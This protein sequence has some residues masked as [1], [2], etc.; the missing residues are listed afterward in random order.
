MSAYRKRWIE[1]LKARQIP[2]W[3]INIHGQA[4][5]IKVPVNEDLEA[6]NKKAGATINA[7]RPEVALPEEWLKFIF[8][9]EKIRFEY[10]L[11]PEP[12][13]IK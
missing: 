11:N 8:Y 9:N 2:G 4:I 10:I 7:L 5:V 3:D 13:L 1:V 12:R 6:I